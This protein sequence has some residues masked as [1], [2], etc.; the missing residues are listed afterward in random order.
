MPSKEST[1]IS[2]TRKMA[3]RRILV[4]EDN[5]D[6][7]ELVAYHLEAQ[8]YVV[9]RAMTGENGVALASSHSPDLIILDVMLPGINGLDV[10]RK[11]R[12][13]ETTRS[14]PVILLT[15]K[16]DETDIVIGLELGV[17]DYI[18]KPFS[19][20]ILIARIRSLLR[21]NEEGTGIPLGLVL[22]IH[23]ITLDKERH[24]VAIEG[25]ERTLSATEF[26]ILAHLM[27]HPGKVFSRSEI[28]SSVQGGPSPVT[29]RSV[30]VHIVHLRK[31]LGSKGDQIETIR[32]YGYRLRAAQ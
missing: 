29:D 9:Y 22:Q 18:T 30:D 24:Q 4:V 1:R 13:T 16:S 27:A 32:G 2:E 3:Y 20:R 7:L 17:D 28:I 12:Q 21:R 6:L 10:F 25:R 23:G 15:A 31:E 11:L 19:P 26:A 8:G 14:I 5:Q